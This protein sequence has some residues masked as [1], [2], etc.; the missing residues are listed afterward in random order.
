MLARAKGQQGFAAQSE[1]SE[2][3]EWELWGDPREVERRKAER[4][5][6]KLPPEARKAQLAEEWVRAKAAAANAKAAA[7]KARQKAAGAV[8]RDLKLEMQQLGTTLARTS[9][10]FPTSGLAHPVSA[11]RGHRTE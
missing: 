1:G 3:E 7:D 5:K 4:K 11:S 10:L 8:I 6:A 2:I 9:T